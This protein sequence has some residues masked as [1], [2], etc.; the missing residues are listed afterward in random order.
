MIVTGI[1]S[2]WSTAADLVLGQVASGFGVFR[3]YGA[4]TIVSPSLAMFQFAI[5]NVVA[6]F[7]TMV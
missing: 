7:P 4:F 2:L 6:T 1:T 3:R 5:G